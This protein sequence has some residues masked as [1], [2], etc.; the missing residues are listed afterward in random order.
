[1]NNNFNIAKNFFEQGEKLFSDKK[2]IEAEKNFNLSLR[3][4]PNRSSTMIN[5]GLCKIKLKK[6]DE[7]LEIINSLKSLE[8]ESFDFQNLKSLY[9]GET[10]QFEKAIKEIDICLKRKNLS[11]FDLAN[12]LNYQGIAYSK[13]KE[14]SKS[15]KLQM[16]AV[17]INKNNYDAQCNIGFNS[18]V[19]GNFKKG[20]EQYE[21]R[22]QRNKLDISKYPQDISSIKNQCILVKSEQGFGDVIMFSR[23][24]PELLNYTSNVDIHI[25]KPL[26]KLFSFKGLNFINFNQI[27]IKDYDYEFYIGSL[28]YLL[29]KEGNL[30]FDK[31]ILNSE[32]FKMKSKSKNKILQVGI[33]W[34]GN[35]NFRYDSMRSL[36]L[37]YF[38]KLFKLDNN[39]VEFYCLQKD[40]RNSDKDYFNQ[41]KI[42]YIGN[43]NF[44]DLSKKIINFD[45]IIS[46]DTSLLHLAASLGCKTFGLI[47]YVPDWRWMLE[48]EKCIWY[49]SLK[50]F[51]QKYRENWTSV[52]KRV[53][54][55]VEKLI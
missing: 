45:L 5:L 3:Y 36:R 4:L 18:L 40:I 11:S 30:V 8:N 37:C 48:G 41:K 22:L 54:F 51:R 50:L 15:L 26:E 52:I 16:K 23:F 38:E 7:C 33:A 10:H 43:L 2:Y 53:S 55:E 9:Y 46:S 14:Y 28:P 1:M 35:K 49:D 6:F 20:W 19:L 44:F 29:K 31:N 42:N 34:S 25:Q 12:L 17:K 47:P 24:L 39:L 21:Y 32:I 27:K 13:I